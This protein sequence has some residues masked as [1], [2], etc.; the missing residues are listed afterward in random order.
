MLGILVLL[1]G[2]PFATVGF[3]SILS[4]PR[5]KEWTVTYAFPGGSLDSQSKHYN[6]GGVYSM[7]YSSRDIVYVIDY[8][9][10]FHD[11]TIDGDVVL[12]YSDLY[13]RTREA[14]LLVIFT[15]EH[16][17][18]SEMHN[19]N[20]QNVLFGRIVFASWGPPE[21]RIYLGSPL[22]L[23]ELQEKGCYG[24][25]SITFGLEHYP[26]LLDAPLFGFASRRFAS[27]FTIIF[28]FIVILGGMS[29]IVISLRKKDKGKNAYNVWENSKSNTQKNT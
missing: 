11:H 12:V 17:F 9:A 27:Y 10:P 22:S 20:L 8:E 29:L 15:D 26:N 5:T 23:D 28:G 1:I 21:I 18:I 2:I 14:E 4:V 13:N 3:L 16:D 6:I 19:L 7:S 25:W 24:N